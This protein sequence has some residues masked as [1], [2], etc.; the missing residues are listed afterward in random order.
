M[1]KEVDPTA[2]GLPTIVADSFDEDALD[3]MVAQAKVSD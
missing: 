3:R 2:T 1:E